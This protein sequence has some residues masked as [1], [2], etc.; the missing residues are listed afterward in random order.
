MPFVERAKTAVA[1]LVLDPAFRPANIE[2]LRIAWHVADHR[3]A[4]EL[5]P[6]SRKC[7]MLCVRQVQI[8]KEQDL[9]A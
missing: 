7:E 3:M 5:A 1:C 9:V 4:L 2:D 8:A 6:D